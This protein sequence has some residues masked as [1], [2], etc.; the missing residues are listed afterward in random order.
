MKNWKNHMKFATA[1]LMSLVVTNLWAANTKTVYNVDIR[2]TINQTSASVLNTNPSVLGGKLNC[3]LANALSDKS[4]KFYSVNPTSGKYSQ[5]STLNSYGHYF[6]ANGLAVSAANQKKAITSEFNGSTAFTINTIAG[7]V[8]DGNIYTW[9][10]ALINTTTADTLEFDFELTIGSEQSVQSDMPLY[11]HRPDKMDAWLAVPYVKVNDGEEER[12]NCVQGNVGDN[13]TF[14]M[15]P[16]N[17]GDEVRFNVRDANNKSLRLYRSEPF[18]LEN[19][20]LENAGSYTLSVI[21]KTAEGKQSSQTCNIYVDVQEHQGEYYDW[22]AHTPFWSYDFRNENPNGFPQPTKVHNFKK[23]NGQ[24]ANVVEG[25]WWSVFWGDGLNAEVGENNYN[26][27]TN[28][29][30]KYDVDFAYIRDE[31]GWPPDINARQG[32]K[33]FVYIFGSGLSNDNTSSTE[34]GGY[35]SSTNVDGRSWPCVWAS[36]Y[37]VSRFRDDADKKWS[38]GDYQREA[39][40]HEGIHALFA[41]YNGV[42]NSAWFHEGGNVWLQMAMN[43]KR[44]NVY[45]SPG[46]LGVGNLICP[47]MPIE[48]YSGWLQ[49]GSFGGPSAEGVNMYNGGQQ[50]CTWRNLIGG[51]QYGEVFPLFLGECVGEGSVPWIWR[52]CRTRVLEGIAKGNTSENVEGIGDEA[53]RQLILQYRARLATM[54]FGGFSSGCRNLLNNYFGT[55][56]KPEWEPYWINVAPFSLTPYQTMEL[57]DDEGWLAPDTITNPGWSG[58][59]IIPIHVSDEG[60]EV[61]FR[62]ED[63]QMRAQLCYRT[64]KGDCYY[65]Q[66][67]ACGKMKLSWTDDNKPANNVVF[68]VVANTDYVYTGDAQRKKHWDYRLKLGEG[69]YQVASEKVK[70]YFYEQN[71][72]DDSFDREAVGIEDVQMD[73][74]MATVPTIKLLSGVLRGGQLVQLDLD[75]ISPKEVTARLVGVSGIMIDEQTVSP[76]NTIQ[77]PANLHKGMYILALHHNGKIDTFKV[78]VE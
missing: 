67:V 8:E 19:V 5:G 78:F 52:Y 48:C 10:Q 60:C 12:N 49:D 1:A 11:N 74:T 39:M 43:A 58:G 15:R 37:P 63:E 24:P 65:S 18:T 2:R 16:R 28:M 29:M 66:P 32:W 30:K 31:M 42:K 6:N 73:N 17:E 76:S 59:N 46:W 53:M 13:I 41:D 9:K 75:G 4:V 35:Q 61:F 50:I 3:V 25:E 77:L 70:W 21:Y 27:M 56:V 20:T 33:S 54:D 40:I 64:K 34:Q 22:K 38:D 72:K 51:V 26:A 14:D 47:F 55:V 71:L 69:A 62:P 44:D 57:N 7:M 68:A 45:G 36:Y 23:K